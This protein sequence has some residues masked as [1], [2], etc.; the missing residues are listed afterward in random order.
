M[1]NAFVPN[2]RLDCLHITLA[3]PT[4]NN[5]V[6]QI[7][8]IG[9]HALLYKVDLRRAYRNLRVDPLDYP[10]LGLKWEGNTYVDVDIVV[11]L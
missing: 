2:D 10:V 7:S 5:L 1:V 11:W 8:K 3:Y 4:I 6:T 9:L